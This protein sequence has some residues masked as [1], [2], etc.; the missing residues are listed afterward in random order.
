MKTPIARETQ[1]KTMRHH[2]SLIKLGEQKE[3]QKIDSI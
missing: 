3:N 2:F 1:F